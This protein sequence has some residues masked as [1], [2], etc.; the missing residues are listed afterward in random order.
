MGHTRLGRLPRTYRWKEVVSLL[1]SGADLSSLADASF[2]AALSGFQLVPADS[3]FVTTIHSIIE[4]A[5][6]AREKDVASALESAGIDRESQ[7]SSFSLLAAVSRKLSAELESA[8]PRSDAGKIARD[9]FVESLTRQVQAKT[10]SLFQEGS[11]DVRKLT[12]PFR[13]NQFKSLM[14]EFYSTF[15]SRYVSYHLSRELPNHVGAGKRFSDL[16][17]HAE[18]NKAFDL[19]CRQT[20]RI[21]DEFTPGW[22]GK[23]AFEKNI[24]RQSVKKYAHVAF[25]KIA[26]EFQKGG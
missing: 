1:E 24:S 17:Q 14:H 21:A 18:F 26:S 8:V 9:A 25:K 11:S 19:H 16:S 7:S 13:G 10:G 15:T 20:V 3:G 23:A 2:K 5:A 12:S 4:L 22:V 6:A